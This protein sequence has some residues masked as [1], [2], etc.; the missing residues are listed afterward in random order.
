M[1]TPVCSA[2][3][4]ASGW[5]RPRSA[6]LSAP[7]LSG[8]DEVFG[9]QSAWALGYGRVTKSMPANDFDAARRGVGWCSGRC[10]C[11]PSSSISRSASCGAYPLTSLSK[12]TNTS[13]PS[14][15]H[16]RHFAAHSCRDASE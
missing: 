15:S 4:T 1:A 2:A 8:R 14:A 6:E 10:R 16:A 11:H 12:Y 3:S 5:S 13:S 9:N 7:P